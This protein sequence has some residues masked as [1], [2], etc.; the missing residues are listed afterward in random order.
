[1]AHFGSLLYRPFL[2]KNIFN[3]ESNCIQFDTSIVLRRKNSEPPKWVKYLPLSGSIV[4]SHYLEVLSDGTASLYV[5]EFPKIAWHSPF[6]PGHALLWPLHVTNNITTIYMYVVLD[7][8]NFCPVR[9]IGKSNNSSLEHLQNFVSRGTLHLY[10]IAFWNFRD[11][12]T[13]V[14][15]VLVCQTNARGLWTKGLELVWKRSRTGERRARLAR[16]AR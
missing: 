10:E 4:F 2:Y 3:E 16:F 14:I 8:R 7:L 13:V 11:C 9:N 1:M 15:F 5:T 12:K 6:N